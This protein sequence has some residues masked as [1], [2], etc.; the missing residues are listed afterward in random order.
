MEP[1]SYT[2][3]MVDIETTGTN[4]D[5]AG[6]LQI[7]AVR[8]NHN[9]QTV[10][11][12]F[13]DRCLTIPPH[14]FWDE[15]TAAWWAKQ[16]KGVLTGILSRQE[17]YRKVIADFAHWCQKCPGTTF[18]AKPT[19]FD[20]MFMSS[21]FKDEGLIF[22]FSY[23]EA[24]DMNSFLYGLHYPNPVPQLPYKDMGDAH[25]AL[26]DTLAQISMV[27]DHINLKKGASGHAESS[28]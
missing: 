3:C 6:I 19:T 26:N 13:F 14:R 15:S 25:N 2:D 11:H 16:K 10:D 17:P 5:R 22:P 23:R 4:P 9:T 1:I 8:F 27:F 18:W 20:F 28:Q 24:K 21:Y 12:D 7:S